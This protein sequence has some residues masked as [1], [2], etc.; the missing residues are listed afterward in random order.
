MKIAATKHRIK[1]WVDAYGIVGTYLSFSGG[2][3]STVLLYI[4]R[5]MLGYTK[6]QVPAVFSNTGLEY[7]EIQRF[8]RQHEA[9]FIRPKMRFDE[10]VSTYGYPII[11]KEVA[12][13]IYYARRIRNSDD[14]N[15]YTRKRAEFLGTRNNSSKQSFRRTVLLGRLPKSGMT[16]AGG[17]FSHPEL[18]QFNTEKWL[19]ASQELPFLIGSKCC[20]V[21]KKRPMHAYGK[22][23]GRVPMMATMAEESRIRKQSWLR[24]GC[25]AYTKDAKSQP[26]AFWTNQDVLQF[27]KEYN[28]EICSVYG[29]II[30]ETGNLKCSGCQRTGCVFCMFGAHSKNDSRFLELQNLS[31]RQFEYAFSGGQWVDNPRYDPVAPVYDGVWKNWNPKKIWVPSK[32]GLGL[33]FVIDQFNEL[34]PNNKIKY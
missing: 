26:M 21:M 28:V 16:G 12:G 10:V 14:A 1:Q 9:E 8:A 25:N 5:M 31:P 23:S 32:D 18:S 33:K 17:A 24:N 19:A 3:D 34:Y 15:T 7:A 22:Q 13:V 29:D 27:I 11:S 20:S 30:G 2:K 4:V 6:E